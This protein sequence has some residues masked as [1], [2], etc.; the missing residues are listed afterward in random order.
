MEMPP[1]SS[2][3]GLV[4]HLS[5]LDGQ[6]SAIGGIGKLDHAIGAAG[7]DLDTTP[8]APRRGVPKCTAPSNEAKVVPS[9]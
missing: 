9:G 7:A 1:P 3:D 2:W 4:A 5:G 6:R 8:F